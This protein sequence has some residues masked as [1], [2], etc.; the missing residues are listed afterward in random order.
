MAKNLHDLYVSGR[1]READTMD[2]YIGPLGGDMRQS[3]RS[4][5]PDDRDEPGGVA[6][7]MKPT[8]GRG[9]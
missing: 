5:Q 7:A 9:R 4:A 8:N 6:P 3:I 2:N 1:K